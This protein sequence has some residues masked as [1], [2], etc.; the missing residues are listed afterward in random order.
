MSNFY[1]FVSGNEDVLSCK[2][3]QFKKNDI[4][5]AINSEK[6][7]V[8]Y[9]SIGKCAIDYIN[10]T[11]T[12]TVKIDINKI[13]NQMNFLNGFTKIFMKPNPI[14]KQ[15]AEDI[16]LEVDLINEYKMLN[17]FYK[18]WKDVHPN[19]KV[20]KPIGKENSESLC[21][22]YHDWKQLDYYEEIPNDILK[23][24]RM[25]FL[26]SVNKYYLIH[27]DMSFYNI[28]VSPD[29]KSICV[30]DYGLSKKMIESDYRELNDMKSNTT[31]F[32]SML[33]KAWDDENHKFDKV[34]EK[35]F[36][37]AFSINQDHKIL[38]PEFSVIFIRSLL[39]LTQIMFKYQKNIDIV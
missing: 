19:I 11:I 16:K 17:E 25:F 35:K 3:Q 18:T 20:P 36:N 27:G 9:G 38:V 39:N 8:I 13:T 30:I 2:I 26:D 22:E 4:K 1:T 29:L 12:K 15:L 31:L 5:N 10:K 28:L 21:M 33:S 24:I 23:L 34:W 7:D 32:G 6:P 14:F 37:E